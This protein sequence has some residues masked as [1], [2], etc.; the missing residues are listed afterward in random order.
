MEKAGLAAVHGALCMVAL[1][2]ASPVMDA[3]SAE[4]PVD[5]QDQE[6]LEFLGE[7]SGVSPELVAFMQSPEAKRAIKDAARETPEKT[8]PVDAAGAQP[9]GSERFIAVGAERWQ[10][11]NDTDRAAA[12]ARFNTW[13]ELPPDERAQVR[14]RWKRFRELTPEQQAAV[15]EAY[16]KFLELPPER[17]ADMSERWRK[18]SPEEQRR[19]VQRRDGGPKP[20]AM[21]TRSCPPC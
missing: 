5:P 20:G 11:M 13:R 2:L 4:S 6:F 16:R 17:R 15:R 3:G 12:R 7:T 10:A 18:M 1:L 19:A 21:D 8:Y 14:D 9:T